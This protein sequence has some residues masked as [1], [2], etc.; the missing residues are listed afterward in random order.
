MTRDDKILKDMAEVKK[1]GD[2]IGYG[3]MMAIATAFWKKLLIDGGG[4]DSGA[5]HGVPKAGIKKDWIKSVESGEKIYDE[6][7]NVFND[8]SKKSVDKCKYYDCAQGRH[9]CCHEKNPMNHCVG[10]CSLYEE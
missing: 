5:F 3:N 9:K 10:V 6:Y 7:L 4:T 2:R 8:E 1:L